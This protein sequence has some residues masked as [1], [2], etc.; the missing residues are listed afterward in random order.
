M[1]ITPNG[2]KMILNQQLL[3]NE[4]KGAD[5]QSYYSYIFNLFAPKLGVFENSREKRRIIFLPF[6]KYISKSD[7][8]TWLFRTY[9]RVK[10]CSSRT[11]WNRP[12][13]HR[14]AFY[15]T[16]NVSSLIQILN[17]YKH[18][19]IAKSAV[20][21][22]VTS[23]NNLWVTVSTK[24]FYSAQMCLQ[25][26]KLHTHSHNLFHNPKRE[27]TENNA[28][29]TRCLEIWKFSPN[30]QSVSVQKRVDIQKLQHYEKSSYWIK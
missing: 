20:V 9:R 1:E 29:T 22:A 7:C 21:G 8:T 17:Y 15:N 2:L 30:I 13:R 27:E 6:Q 3:V 23:Y 14:H 11:S 5:G 10:C 16:Q 28:E 25:I 18:G 24:N 4:I 26:G 12:T 19:C